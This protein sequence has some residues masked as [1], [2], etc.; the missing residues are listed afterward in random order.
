MQMHDRLAPAEAECPELPEPA[1]CGVCELP[2]PE[3]YDPV[4]EVYKRDI[5]R[6]LLIENLSLT[7]AERVEKLR[8]FVEFLA[9]IRQA[10]RRLRGESQ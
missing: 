3:V 1:R 6:T 8:D 2:P 7:P 9:E 5:D 4:V 10:W